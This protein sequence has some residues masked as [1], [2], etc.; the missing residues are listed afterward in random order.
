MKM[1]DFNII[2]NVKIVEELKAELLC[3]IGDF[4]KLLVKGSNASEKAILE[5]ISGAIIILYILADR[6]GYSNRIVDEE[7]KKKLKLGIIEKDNIEVEGKD[8]S[9]L[10]NYL[11]QRD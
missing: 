7:I 3:I 8:L 5:C 6:L 10:Y 1:E 4:Y 9:K 2:S 11:K